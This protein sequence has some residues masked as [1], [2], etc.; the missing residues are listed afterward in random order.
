M[1]KCGSRTAVR[2]GGPF[3]W[4]EGWADAG[5]TEG[6]T[7]ESGKAGS[8]WAGVGRSQSPGTP[9]PW[10]GAPL[11]FELTGVPVA[12]PALVKTA[13]DFTFWLALFAFA[14]G[15]GGLRWGGVLD[16]LLLGRTFD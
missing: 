8:G 9:R 12:S 11:V 3:A 2:T 15:V 7:L 10:R 4:M 1:V 14:L 5:P 6:W 13:G 16:F